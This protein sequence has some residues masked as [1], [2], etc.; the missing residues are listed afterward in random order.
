MIPARA[1]RP[2]GT[3]I[4]AANGRPRTARRRK[5]FRR[6]HARRLQRSALGAQIP[7]RRGPPRVHGKCPRYGRRLASRANTTGQPL[8]CRRESVEN[9]CDRALLGACPVEAAAE[10]EH[11]DD[12]EHDTR[13]EKQ[14]ARGES[15]T[16]R[17][18]RGGLEHE[19]PD[20]RGNEKRAKRCSACMS[21]R[22]GRAE[23]VDRERYR[24]TDDDGGRAEQDRA[25]VGSPPLRLCGPTVRFSSTLWRVRWNDS[26]GITDECQYDA[27]RPGA[28]WR[29]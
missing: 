10:Q 21:S 18:I 16:D 20:R 11:R 24:T 7:C 19:H 12:G 8:P 1:L 23:S 6:R 15:V 22:R 26:L 5:L 13:K 2:D 29:D 14:E 27:V 17:S 3:P 28:I 25:R 9:G 4:K